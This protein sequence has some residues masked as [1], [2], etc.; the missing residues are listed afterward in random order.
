MAYTY[1]KAVQNDDGTFGPT[2]V[3]HYYKPVA[4][5]NRGAVKKDEKSRWCLKRNEQ[6]E[7]FRLADAML[8]DDL[9]QK[10]NKNSLW[11]QLSCFESLMLFVSAVLP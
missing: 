5:H 11:G 8:V 2:N 6:Y 3:Q 9:K 1:P 10:Q 4:Y 7:M